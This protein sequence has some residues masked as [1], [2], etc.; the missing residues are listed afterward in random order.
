MIDNNDKTPTPQSENPIDRKS[1]IFRNLPCFL[2]KCAILTAFALGMI[3][4]FKNHPTLGLII[5][6]VLCLLIMIC[7]SLIFW[8]KNKDKKDGYIEKE[9]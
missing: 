4:I 1:E 9:G 3:E 2:A 8:K 7:R 6:S 5:V